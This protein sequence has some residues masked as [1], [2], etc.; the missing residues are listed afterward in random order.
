MPLTRARFCA[1]TA[2]ISFNATVAVAARFYVRRRKKAKYG[3]DDW[4][5]LASLTTGVHVGAFRHIVERCSDRTLR[6]ARNEEP[7]E[8][9]DQVWILTV[10][11]LC[12]T[13][14]SV[15]FLYR[16]LFKIERI[17]NIYT[18]FLGVLLVLW[19]IAL[20]LARIFRCGLEISAQWDSLS[21]PGAHCRPIHAISAAFV[22]SDVVTDVMVLF[23]PVPI[24]WRMRLSRA[25]RVGVL[26]ILGL[27]LL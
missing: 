20:L 7:G 11:C 8:A 5:I 23:A 6:R 2:V 21:N 18:I 27:G 14:L 10:V 3:A 13:K 26:A 4:T 17:F 9:A 1:L 12:T 25:R 24:V 22:I 19:S 16:R 15:V